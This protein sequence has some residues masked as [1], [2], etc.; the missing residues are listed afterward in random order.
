MYLI[1][2]DAFDFKGSENFA[3]PLVIIHDLFLFL[4]RIE[5]QVHLPKLT[6]VMLDVA[7]LAFVFLV[8]FQMTW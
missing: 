8:F 1:E 4:K 5:A 2:I 7:D 6:S 3:P